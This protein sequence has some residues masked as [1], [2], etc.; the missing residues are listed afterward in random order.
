VID[1]SGAL[2]CLFGSVAL[3]CAASPDRDET[4]FYA[5]SSI[6][7]EAAYDPLA[8]SLQYVLDSVQVEQFG[9]EDYGD[10]LEIV[11]EH[12]GDPIHAIDSEGGWVRFV[13]TEIVP[14]DPENISDSR[15]IL[16]NVALHTFGGGLLYRKDA[17][18]FAAHGVPEPYVVSACLAMTTEVL[19][20][21]I[22]KPATDDTDEIADVYLF[23]PLGIW[24]YSDDDRARWIREELDAVDW[25]NLL[26][27]SVEEDDFVNTG[28][29]YVVRPRWLGDAP[30][31]PF[32]YLGMTTLFGLSHDAGDTDSVSWG[33][34]TTTLAVDP[35]D[36]RG[37][38]GLFYDRGRSLLASILFNAGEGYAVRAN[39]Y[40]G[41]LFDTPI[42]L[43]A[44][45]S[46]DGDVAVGVHYQL[47]IGLSR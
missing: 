12:L 7:S 25:P 19:A 38:A 5:P 33:I 37:S 29:S 40:P 2:A 32:A 36:L 16:P 30:V 14:I 13:N 6:G 34:G 18:W 47:P 11:L 15:S 42:G 35:V 17:E 1:R 10:H 21:A 31:R 4:V 27:W 28:S 44:G 22:E 3:A 41:V 46:D 24:L 43:F 39:I 23:R 45:V 20:E 9:T 8:S 26:M